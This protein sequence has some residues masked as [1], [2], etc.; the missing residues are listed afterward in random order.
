[1]ALLQLIYDLDDPTEGLRV[2]GFDFRSAENWEVGQK[3]F[4]NWWFVLDQDIVRRS[5]FLRERRGAVK[6]LP[7]LQRE[8][9]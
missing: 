2:S 4:E 6:L 5:N 1:M 8:C 7:P 9:V 3:V